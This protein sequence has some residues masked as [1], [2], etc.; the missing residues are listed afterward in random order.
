[1]TLLSDASLYPHMVHPPLLTQQ[2]PL[3]RMMTTMA[4]TFSPHA[5][6]L[7]FQRASS[8]DGERFSFILDTFLCHM[9]TGTW[10]KCS[11]RP[12]ALRMLVRNKREDAPM[13]PP[14]TRGIRCARS[15]IYIASALFPLYVRARQCFYP[16]PLYEGR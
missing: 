2:Q 6:S 12:L 9:V 8:C 10:I 7:S 1:M 5:I 16:T 11:A 3:V 15:I 4:L 13:T 14:I